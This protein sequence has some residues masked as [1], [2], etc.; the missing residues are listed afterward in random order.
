MEKNLSSD[1][2]KD[3]PVDP[4]LDWLNDF[5][6]TNEDKEIEKFLDSLEDML[7]KDGPF[8]EY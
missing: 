7:V 8:G 1:W 5:E 3:I 2:A 4:K 6:K